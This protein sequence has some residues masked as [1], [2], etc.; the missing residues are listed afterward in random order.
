VSAGA[1]AQPLTR[2]SFNAKGLNSEEDLND[3]FAGNFAALAFDRGSLSF[4]ALFQAYLEA[5]SSQCGAFLPR[6]KVEMTAQVCADAP[7]P[8]PLPNRPPPIQQGCM[9]WRTVSLGFAKPD[10]YAARKQLDADQA[11]NQIKDM[12]SMAKTLRPAI[13]S[14]KAK[15]EMELLVRKNAC[16]G[17]GLLRFEENLVL[18]AKAKPP[19]VLPG[20]PPPTPQMQGTLIDS[21]F[22]KLTKDLIADQ[23]T[24]WRVNRYVPGSTS[25]LIVQH[26]PHGR[27]AIIRAKYSF[28]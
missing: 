20:A 21:D 8:P 18:F 2:A 26:D 27:P 23:A 28:T 12:V 7:S 16:N 25:Q 14:F 4:S 17:P 5:F 1:W 6:N 9:S 10:L 19:L 24:A 3:L 15:V 22:N 11:L 13:D